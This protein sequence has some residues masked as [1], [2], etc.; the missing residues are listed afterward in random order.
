[1]YR[2]LSTSILA[3]SASGII[4]ILAVS[5]FVFGPMLWNAFSLW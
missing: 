5:P 2:F 3:V 1:M 4:F